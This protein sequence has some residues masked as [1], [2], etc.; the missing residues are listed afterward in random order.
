MPVSVTVTHI[1]AGVAV[2][3]LDE[4]VGDGVA[5][6]CQVSFEDESLLAIAVAMTATSASFRS[7]SGDHD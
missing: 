1:N 2:G 3:L 7:R 6:L 5:D 4:V